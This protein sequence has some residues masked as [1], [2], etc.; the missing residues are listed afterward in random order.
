M[1]LLF[2]MQVEQAKAKT[3][4]AIDDLVKAAAI[5]YI[6]QAQ[7]VTPVKDG[8]LRANQVA[9]IHVPSTAKYTT[10]EQAQNASSFSINRLKFSRIRGAPVFVTNTTPYGRE[11]HE[12]GSQVSGGRSGTGVAPRFWVTAAEDTARIINSKRVIRR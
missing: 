2:R 10:R 8:L 6:R 7:A 1:S 3:F 4:D 9:S 11:V 5:E 12:R